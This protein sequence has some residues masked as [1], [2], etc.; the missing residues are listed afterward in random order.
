MKM[1]KTLI[2]H[3]RVAMQMK[4]INTRTFLHLASFRKRQFLELRNS[5]LPP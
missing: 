1:K 4:F 3:F 2:G 5:L